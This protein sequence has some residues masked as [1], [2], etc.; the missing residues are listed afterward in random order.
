MRQIKDVERASVSIETDRALVDD[1]PRVHNLYCAKPFLPGAPHAPLTPTRSCRA[2]STS[3]HSAPTVGVFRKPGRC[4]RTTQN[5]WPLAPPSPPSAQAA[6]D[7][8]P[9]LFEPRDFRGDVVGFDA[10]WTRLS[11]SPAGSA[12]SARRAGSPASDSRRGSRWPGSTGRPSASAR[13]RPRRP[14]HQSCSRSARR[15]GGIDCTSSTPIR[16]SRRLRCH[17][18]ALDPK[19][20]SG[21]RIRS[22]AKLKDVEHDPFRKE[23]IVLYDAVAAAH[24]VDDTRRGQV[25]GTHRRQ[26]S[27]TR[28][29]AELLRGRFQPGGPCSR[30]IRSSS[31]TDAP[32]GV[33]TR[34]EMPRTRPIANL[35]VIENVARAFG[36]DCEEQVR[37]PSLKKN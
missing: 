21:F 12:R 25:N 5:R 18:V 37:S 10:R 19:S 33:T 8:G 36:H 24:R 34:R 13:N 2:V 4:T 1:R 17:V 22:C 14:H 29:R 20:V 3:R 28:P 7:L 16:S 27:G 35:W 32:S 31:H 6:C 15:R 23:R 26:A 30:M 11:W 9:E